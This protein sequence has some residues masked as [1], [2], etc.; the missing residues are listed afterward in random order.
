MGLPA[1]AADYLFVGPQM[2]ARLLD[3]VPDIA[4]EMV[5]RPDQVLEADKRARVL[6]V[7]WGGDRFGDEA[8]AGGSQVVYQRWMVLLGIN[9]VAPAAAARNTAVGPMLS[10][11]H[12]ALAGWAPDGSPR[13]LRRANAALQP[14]FTQSKAVYPLGFELQLTL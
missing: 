6:M 11:V 10:Q 9:S 13:S 5:E 12:R 8:R 7:M 14:L 2:V 3:Q 1:L 4:V